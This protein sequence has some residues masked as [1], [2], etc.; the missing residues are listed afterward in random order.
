MKLGENPQLADVIFALE[1]GPKKQRHS[2]NMK[3]KRS[4][5]GRLSKGHERIIPTKGKPDEKSITKFP[6]INYSLQSN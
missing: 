4:I 6:G 2:W 3:R 1:G 5:V